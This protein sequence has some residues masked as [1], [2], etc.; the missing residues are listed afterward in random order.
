MLS[1]Y[2]KYSSDLSYIQHGTIGTISIQ[3]AV[4]IVNMSI[5]TMSVRCCAESRAKSGQ[6]SWDVYLASR[7][8]RDCDLVLSKRLCAEES[9]PITCAN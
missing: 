1:N 5:A 7:K 2:T 4:A 9:Q 3:V 6:G 8:E